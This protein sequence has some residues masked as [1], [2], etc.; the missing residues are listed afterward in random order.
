MFNLFPNSVGD[1]VIDPSVMTQAQQA[2]HRHLSSCSQQLSDRAFRELSYKADFAADW[3]KLAA[4]LG[5]GEAEIERIAGGD[6]EEACLKMLR[7]WKETRG[8]ATVAVLVEA[9]LKIRNFP[10]LEL[11]DKVYTL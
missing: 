1:G 6:R 5:L 10:L 2:V 3:E 4:K 7:Q 9:I 8:E 11:L